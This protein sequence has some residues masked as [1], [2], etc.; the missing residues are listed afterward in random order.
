MSSLAVPS[1]LRTMSG[2]SSFLRY[3][4]SSFWFH[5]LKLFLSISSRTGTIWLWVESTC[6]RM[7]DSGRNK[8]SW[9]ERRGKS[10]R[11]SQW[12]SSRGWSQLRT[13]MPSGSHYASLLCITHVKV[14]AINKAFDH[15]VVTNSPPWV[16]LSVVWGK[17]TSR[18]GLPT[19]VYVQE[20]TTSARS[21]PC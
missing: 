19:G 21:A 16:R 8:F 13:W 18:P 1:L 7:Y 2:C 9:R 4:T 14:G 15:C 6:L 10:W 11:R 17:L 20:E 12:R 3:C 5:W